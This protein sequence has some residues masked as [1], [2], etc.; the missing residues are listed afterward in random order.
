[1]ADTRPL[2]RIQHSWQHYGKMI[3]QMFGKESWLEWERNIQIKCYF[4]MERR[5]HKCIEGICK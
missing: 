4:G 2:E 1:M 3:Y 5:S